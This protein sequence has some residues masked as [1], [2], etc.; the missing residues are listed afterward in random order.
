MLIYDEH[1]I[2]CNVLFS[3]GLQS[4]GGQDLIPA[5]GDQ[6]TL[7]PARA[8]ETGVTILRALA[9]RKAG[10]ERKRES[11]G[12]KAFRRQGARH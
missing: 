10:R 2:S 6:G 4:G 5:H 3:P 9:Q 8:P 1:T 11:D 12:R 7:D